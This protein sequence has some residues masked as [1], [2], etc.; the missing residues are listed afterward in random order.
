VVLIGLVIVAAAVVP[1][2]R[3]AGHQAD[4]TE[5]AARVAASARFARDEAMQRQAAIVLSV[6]SQPAELRLAVDTSTVEGNGGPQGI[7]SPMPGEMA[8]A[9]QTGPQS[10]LL[11]LPAAF[12][13]VPLGTHIQARLEG[14][15]ETFNGSP[16]GT[17][18]TGGEVS[19]IRFPA[20]GR[21]T[22][23]VVVLTDDRGRT[24]HVV[25]TPDTGV[26]QVE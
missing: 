25:V 21:T 11:P 2:L 20:D 17:A 12:A 1:A 18:S 19:M 7:N 14:V 22:G 16:T 15:A 5:V 6:Q 3:G 8:R 24:L 13:A 26:V 4:V 10:P 9:G 23:G